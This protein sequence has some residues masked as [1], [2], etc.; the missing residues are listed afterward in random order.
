MLGT[1]IGFCSI[2]LKTFCDFVYIW[3]VSMLCKVTGHFSS[4]QMLTILLLK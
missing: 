2:I 4:S 3:H 1:I